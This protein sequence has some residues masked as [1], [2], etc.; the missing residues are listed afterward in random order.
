MA[1][2]VIRN[3]RIEGSVPEDE[4]AGLSERVRSKRAADGGPFLR[5]VVDPGE[6]VVD[7]R[8]VTVDRIDTIEQDRVVVSY[9]VAAADLA[10]VK[11]RALDLIDAM[12]LPKPNGKGEIHEAKRREA[13]AA[14]DDPA[15]ADRLPDG[16]VKY[17][18]IEA[19]TGPDGVKI[20]AAAEIILNRS[21]EWA[22]LLAGREG[23]R[24]S[25]KAAV[26]AAGDVDAVMAI[27]RGIRG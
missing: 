7:E 17:P 13:L 21:L 6:P 2:A 20:L 3:G 26:R 4:Y 9:L 22:A 27:T 8:L 24:L 19:E 12:L 16:R 5:L 25:A 10:D 1:Y 11:A 14:I 18:L 15:P 23:A